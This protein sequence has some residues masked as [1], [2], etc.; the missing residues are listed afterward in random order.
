VLRGE[1]KSAGFVCAVTDSL[2]ATAS[3]TVDVQAVETS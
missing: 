2:G 3:A 1:T